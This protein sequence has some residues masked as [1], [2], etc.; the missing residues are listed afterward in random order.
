MEGYKKLLDKEKDTRITHILD[1]TDTYLAD[2]GA[3]VMSQKK[4]GNNPD[5][6][7]PE[8]NAGKNF[9]QIAHSQLETV[10]A[11]SSLLVG[12]KLKEYQLKGS[13]FFLPFF[14]LFFFSFFLSVSSPL[15]FHLLQGWSG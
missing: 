1:Q 4:N 13:F 9:Y 3:K 11:Q 15:L 10:A 12:G 5:Q 6:A 7:E 8:N 14:S 2:L